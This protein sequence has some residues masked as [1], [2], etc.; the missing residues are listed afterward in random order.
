MPATCDKN[1]LM[2]YKASSFSSI[3]VLL[4]LSNEKPITGKMDGFIFST[5][6][7]TSAGIAPLAWLMADSMR[8]CVKST[9]V[10]Q[11]TKADISQ[12][13]LLV[14]LRI[15]VM[16]GTFLMAVSSGLVTVTIILLTG[17]SPASAIIFILGKVISGNK[18]TCRFW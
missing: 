4:W 9:F 15:K 2:V 12:L 11:S 7:F 17:C 6:T 13:P 16:P 8:C 14:V 5:V 10:F 18:E 3:G 1:G